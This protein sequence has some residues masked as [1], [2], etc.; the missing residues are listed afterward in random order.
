M[1]KVVGDDA[2]AD[3]SSGYCP[4][5]IGRLQLVPAFEVVS[6]STVQVCVLSTHDEPTA[7]PCTASLKA[8]AAT[9]MFGRLLGVGLGPG[10]KQGFP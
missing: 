5:G 4:R 8:T 6:A 9:A 10:L 2:P 7:H 3:V 1:F